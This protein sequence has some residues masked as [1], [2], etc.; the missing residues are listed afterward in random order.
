MKKLILFTF[1]VASC[2]PIE[3]TTQPQTQDDSPDF[4]NIKGDE[5]MIIPHLWMK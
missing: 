1:L 3:Q 4:I 5:V 2:K